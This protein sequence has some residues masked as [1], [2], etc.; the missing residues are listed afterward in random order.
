VGNRLTSE[1]ILSI[2]KI[3]MVN[4]GEDGKPAAHGNTRSEASEEFIKD[5]LD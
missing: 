2:D 1:D 3:I 5:R 4:L